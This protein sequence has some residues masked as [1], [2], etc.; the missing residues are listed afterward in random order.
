M[1]TAGA[2]LGFV[3]AL[4]PIILTPG[5]SFTLVT[6]RALVGDRRGSVAVVIGTALGIVTHAILAG[7]G[8]AAVV[9]ASSQ[10]FA[11]VRLLGAGVM[12]VLG[13]HL[14]WQ[15][16]TGRSKAP[17]A[18]VDPKP[19]AFWATVGQA[20][21]ANVLNMKAAAIYLT[22][23]PQFLSPGQAAVPSMLCLAGLHI[24][25]QVTWLSFWVAGWERLRRRFDPAVWRRRID[26]LGGLV[27]VVLGV[28][29]AVAGR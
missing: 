8:L 12:I 15:A 24:V 2:A 4:L 11:V 9:M 29:S 1:V 23:A 21:A 5:A 13:L 18:Q 16:R 25:V 22:L 28:R 17:V 27:L 14:L 10:A 7:L 3:L 26:A 6:G 20:Y 19:V